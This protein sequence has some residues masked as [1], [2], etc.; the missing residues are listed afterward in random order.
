MKNITSS[1]HSVT[2]S[3]SISPSFK[4]TANASKPTNI[5][6]TAIFIFIVLGIGIISGCISMIYC[7]YV[8]K[9]SIKMQS[10]ENANEIASPILNLE[11]SQENYTKH[12]DSENL[13]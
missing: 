13:N 7:Y 9:K 1:Y 10:K 11:E 2:S 6:I 12:K 5:K 8:H 4:A 3:A